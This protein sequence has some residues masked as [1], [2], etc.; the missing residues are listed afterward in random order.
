[1]G[2][3]DRITKA[4]KPVGGS[5]ALFEAFGVPAEQ[6]TLEDLKRYNKTVYTCVRAISQ[7]VGNIEIKLKK[8]E[9]E[10]KSHWLLDLLSNPNPT[11]RLSTY[12]LFE[13]TQTYIELADEAFWY[14][15]KGNETGKPKLIFLLRPDKMTVVPASDGS[16]K[17]YV[18]RKD[19][20]DKIP[21][22][23]NEIVH[24]KTPNPLNQYRGY[25]VT[26]ASRDFIQTDEYASKWVRNSFYNNARPSALISLKGNISDNEFDKLKKNWKKQYGGVSNASKTAFIKGADLDYQELSLGLD[27]VAI[28]EIKNMTR[29]DVMFMF[30]VSKPMLGILED[31]NLAS[32]RSANYA[33]MA[34]V[35]KP[36]M[37][38]LADTLQQYIYEEQIDVD[39]ENPV[40]ADKVEQADYFSKMLNV[41]LTV[42][43]I[44]AEI[45]K[46]PISDGD[47]IYQPMN[48]VPVGS[49]IKQN[50]I[51]TVTTK[52]LK[53]KVV[54][55][56]I[57]DT[58]VNKNDSKLIHWRTMIGIRNSWLKRYL[59][60]LDKVLEAEKKEV[61]AKLAGKKKD[62]DVVVP[63]PIKGGET[64]LMTIL[65]VEL[66]LF[67]D[68]AE[69]ASTIVGTEVVI[70]K[71]VETRLAERISKVF[72]EFDST[73]V[74]TLKKS[75]AEG[76]INGESLSQIA[77]RVSEVY[78]PY[79]KGG[80]QAERLARTETK[81]ISNEG[82]METYSQSQ[83][84]TGKEW[85]ANPD[86]CG[87][88]Q[89]M[90]GQVVDIENNFLDIGG[91]VSYTDD[92]GDLQT[93]G[94]N[95]DS[96]GTADLHPN[97]E[98]LLLPWSQ[99]FEDTGSYSTAK[100]DN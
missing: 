13:M 88:C 74:E 100:G 59:Y 35:I 65:P 51:K 32:A 60:T 6:N 67:T 53:E 62:I 20:G 46:P 26:R 41:G 56:S 15:A 30:R 49:P 86:A 75:I 55:K 79:V 98:C 57:N 52:T 29:D 28:K 78:K 96:I 31:V 76:Y 64:W 27:K 82:A 11:L 43:E 14:M 44:R 45:G 2:I 42:N 48:L 93:M 3:F 84:V 22:D 66:G 91:S 47:F 71:A 4:I 24:F 61:L 37:E 38:M 90:N 92:K 1:M 68:E 80:Y 7:E 19:N 54:P 34:R 21:F 18:L 50:T 40:E 63:D 87:F 97:C 69:Y 73:R 70:G 12:S 36:K 23:L 16:I 8:N 95:Y 9:K 25:G 81:L 10:L 5:S 89:E 17:G 39:F 58:T 77:D 99:E 83:V 85:Y 72:G 94:I 33:F